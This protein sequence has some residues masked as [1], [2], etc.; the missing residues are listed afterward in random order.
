[1]SSRTDA[2]EKLGA[3][4]LGR[5]VDPRSGETLD[6]PLLYDAK[7]LTTHAVCVGMTGSG[8]TGLCV[9]LLEEAAIDGVPSLVIDPKGDLANLLLTFPDLAPADFLP[10]VDPGE[11][12]R[13]GRTPQQH[14]EAKAELW[15]EGLASWDQDGERIRRLREAAEFAIY[16]PGS[17]AGRQVSILSSFGAPPPEVLEDRDALNERIQT[18]ASSLL[19]LLGID[20]DPIKSREA[21]L[22]AK[23][24]EA[25][26]QEGQDL[27]LASLILQLQ[28]PPF[29]TIGVL[30]LE[31][32][33]P[34]DKRFEL[35]MALNNLLASPT[36][37]SWLEGDPLD[38]DDL[39]YTAEGK[40]RVTVFSI[41]HLSDAERMFFVSLLL[42]QTLGW[43]RT[44]A[45][46][47]SLRAIL[48]MDEIFG[49]LPPVG[50]PPSKK[51]LLTMLKQARAFGVGLV[52]A[53]QNPVDLDYKALSNIGT[54]FLGRL[55]TER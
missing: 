37:Q 15:R 12:A 42:G 34:E 36:F 20:A 25:S 16:T 2:Y 50:S 30:P 17:E 43:M 8:K 28:T 44:R 29:E 3:F 35:A 45:G 32:F 54:W 11:A 4:Y 22:L 47:S 10:W 19:A 52:L 5:E 51:P 39:L 7:D 41:A 27:D 31:S 18:T 40:P 55:Q 1:M 23:L 21:I 13:E 48:Y 26:W 6:A 14:A 46:T 53:T 24:F 38:V 49:Y 9:T 33:Y